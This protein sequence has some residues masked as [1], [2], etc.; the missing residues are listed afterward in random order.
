MLAADGPDSAATANFRSPAA[1]E[2][3]QASVLFEVAARRGACSRMC[4]ARGVPDRLSVVALQFRP[5]IIQLREP[6]P[7]NP[8]RPAG[9]KGKRPGVI[10]F[11]HC[12]D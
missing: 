1:G 4:Y 11:A 5:V 10:G 9:L 12:L 7:A 2:R 6:S 8:D 3:R